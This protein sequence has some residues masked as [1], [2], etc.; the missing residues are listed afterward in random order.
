MLQGRLPPADNFQ[1]T[2]FCLSQ[3]EGF[4]RTRYFIPAHFALR[5]DSTK[6]LFRVRL[7]DILDDFH[8]LGLRNY[9]EV[10]RACMAI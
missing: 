6:K 2:D 10:P 1:E 5:C 7:L 4:P 3:S 8:D 9:S